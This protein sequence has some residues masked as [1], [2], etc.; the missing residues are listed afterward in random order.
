MNP[1]RAAVFCLL[2][3]LIAGAPGVPALAGEAVRGAVYAPLYQKALI[4]HRG[5]SLPLTATVYVRNTDPQAGLEVSA[6]TLYDG[7]GKV[8]AKCLEG[9][10]R[11][12]PLASLSF[13]A[14]SAAQ[15]GGAPSL[16]VRWR[17]PQP[18]NPPMVQVVMTGAAGQQGISLI[19][20]GA[21]LPLRP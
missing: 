14:P 10:R 19:T 6:V 11:L 16:V 3:I 13:L 18:V 12:A 4:D 5:R 9:P 21:P 7:R 1:L 20:T 8:V 17:A 15:G 2:L